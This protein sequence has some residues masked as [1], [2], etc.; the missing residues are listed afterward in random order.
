MTYP[1]GSIPVVS[2]V[3]VPASPVVG[4]SSG[5]ERL[6]GFGETPFAGPAGVTVSDSALKCWFGD[7]R[8]GSCTS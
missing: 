5:Y 4:T 6:D 1:H 7:V 3:H 2:S 8:P